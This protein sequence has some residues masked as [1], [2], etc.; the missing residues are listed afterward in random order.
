MSY[1]F[2]SYSQRDAEIAKKIVE[3]LNQHDIET[4]TDSN[5]KQGES[6]TESIEKAV[7]AASAGILI[8]SVAAANSTYVT[9]EYRRLLA[10]NKRLYVVKVD[11]I[12]V[13]EIHAPLLNLQY[14]D[15]TVDF[16]SAMQALVDAI[17][18]TKPLDS[19]TLRKTMSDE[20]SDGVVL[21][22]DWDNANSDKMVDMIK[23]LL[24]KGVRNIRITNG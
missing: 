20:V 21:E 17:Q 10:L 7:D 1:I 2:V 16:D 6:M 5:I 8:L 11:D 22:V 23:G 18:N 15:A 4:W 13:D 19:P 14:V 12:P 3:Y 9:L 24:D